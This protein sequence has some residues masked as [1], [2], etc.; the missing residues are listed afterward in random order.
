LLCW[1]EFG[2]EESPIL[3]AIEQI[4]P[5]RFA[6]LDGLLF[7]LLL[8]RDAV[9][10]MDARQA[11]VIR[12][13]LEHA[14]LTHNRQ[15]EH[16]QWDTFSHV[17]RSRMLR[18]DPYIE[19]TQQG[20]DYAVDYLL[21]VFD[22]TPQHKGGKKRK[23]PSLLERGKVE[24]R[25]RRKVRMN[26]LAHP[27]YRPDACIGYQHANAFNT[28]LHENRAPIDRQ[29]DM[30][31]ATKKKHQYPRETHDHFI[32]RSKPL[33]IPINSTHSRIPHVHKE[34]HF[35]LSEPLTEYLDIELLIVPES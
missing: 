22:Q 14:A 29:L 3:D 8:Y 10:S 9:D 25:W 4:E 28:W 30:G 6:T 35:L 19:P 15:N 27:G 13:K 11:V 23:H 18:W 7:L 24:R 12:E 21:M 33:Q 32:N 1:P 16:E 31:R 17:M 20:L 26:A 2:N 34:T 5:D